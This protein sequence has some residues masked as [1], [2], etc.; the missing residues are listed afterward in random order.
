MIEKIEKILNTEFE[1]VLRAYWEH[2]TNINKEYNKYIIFNLEGTEHKNFADNI[3]LINVTT[4]ILRYY[5]RTELIEDYQERKEIFLI[6]NKIIKVM[7]KNN[8]SLVLGG[9]NIGNY[10]MAGFSGMGFEFLYEDLKNEY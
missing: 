1:N 9:F 6:K 3:G 7:E 8:F 2:F 4:I 5:Y 10:D